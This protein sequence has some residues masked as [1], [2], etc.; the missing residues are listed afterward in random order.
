MGTH[1]VACS[2]VEFR[3]ASGGV[4]RGPGAPGRCPASGRWHRTSWAA[5]AS[6]LVLPPLCSKRIESSFG[7][8]DGV[9]AM[10]TYVWIT[11]ILLLGGIVG[12]ALLFHDRHAW[13]R[14][15]PDESMRRHVNKNY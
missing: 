11:V 12:W 9:A 10:R 3:D 13:S 2:I 7:L 8:G 14:S 6:T 5:P 4:P 1:S 15:K